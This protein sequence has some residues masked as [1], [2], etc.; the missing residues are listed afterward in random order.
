MTNIGPITT[1]LQPP[2]TEITEDGE[3]LLYCPECESSYLHHTEV[4]VFSRPIEDGPVTATRVH[5]N[6]SVH[7][8]PGHWKGNPSSR[9]D[10]VAIRFYCENCD[11]EAQLTIAQHKGETLLAWRRDVR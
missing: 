6:A 8:L 3:A 10:G 5:S 1:K 9:R 2:R 11:L 7:V 4:T